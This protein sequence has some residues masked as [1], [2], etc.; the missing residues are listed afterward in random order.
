MSLVGFQKDTYALSANVLSDTDNDSSDDE[1]ITRRPA[2]PSSL[3]GPPKPVVLSGVSDLADLERMASLALD[4]SGG[5]GAPR[6]LGCRGNSRLLGSTPVRGPRNC[7]TLCCEVSSFSS[8]ELPEIPTP[9]Y[10]FSKC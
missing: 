1:P 9:P 6:V 10:R 8:K 5:N 3:Q 7:T 2:P 4:L